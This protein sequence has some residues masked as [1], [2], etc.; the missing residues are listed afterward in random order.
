MSPS[1]AHATMGDEALVLIAELQAT[2]GLGDTLQRELQALVA[3]TLTEPGCLGLALHRSSDDPDLLLIYEHWRSRAALATH[4]NLPHT[5]DFFA[6][7][8]QWLAAEVRL[9]HF[10]LQLPAA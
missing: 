8:P 10:G 6:R 3:A 5:R 1:D 4:V 7:S 9:R 2:P